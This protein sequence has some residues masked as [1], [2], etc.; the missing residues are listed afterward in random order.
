M[1][2]ALPLRPNTRGE[3][4]TQHPWAAP[5]WGQ[6]G[7]LWQLWTV[8]VT[9]CM[10]GLRLGM[11]SQELSSEQPPS[12]PCDLVAS[13]RQVLRLAQGHQEWAPGH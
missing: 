3:D 7:G 10:T 5:T 8:T 4:R 2:A 12:A 11:C 6:P 9:I 1:G 13:L